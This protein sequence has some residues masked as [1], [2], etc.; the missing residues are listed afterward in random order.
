ML[1]AN[2]TPRGY[3]QEKRKKTA[4][5]AKGITFQKAKLHHENT[6][7][8]MSTFMIVYF[9]LLCVSAVFVFVMEDLAIAVVLAFSTDG[10]TL[11]F[12]ACDVGFATGRF[13]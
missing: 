9:H 11:P 4:S 7:L 5:T 10:V 13:N 6:Y 3:I 12:S 8:H 2:R 1:Y